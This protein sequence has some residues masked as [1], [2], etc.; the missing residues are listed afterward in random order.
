MA[1]NSQLEKMRK[2]F[3]F[4]IIGTV[5]IAICISI[6]AGFEIS[7][8]KTSY[9][10]DPSYCDV[11]VTREEIEIANMFFLGGIVFL[12]LPVSRSKVVLIVGVGMTMIGLG[13]IMFSFLQV[14]GYIFQSFYNMAN[15]GFIGLIVFLIGM[16]T[17]GVKGLGSLL[18]FVQNL[19][20]R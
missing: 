2:S 4:L 5:M 1:S 14:N 12:I 19:R 13:V 10:A 8:V 3:K 6:Y 17:L 20:A 16:F 11:I 7:G 15:I 9:C 18:G